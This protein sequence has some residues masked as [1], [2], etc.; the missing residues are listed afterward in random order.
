[1]SP[2]IPDPLLVSPGTPQL[3][4]TQE[5]R[6]P[7]RKGVILLKMIVF[8]QLGVFASE[9]VQSYGWVRKGVHKGVGGVAVGGCRGALLAKAGHWF[10]IHRAIPIK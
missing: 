7:K 4:D 5:S 3:W 8:P 1:M 6:S 9:R 10:L 2:Y